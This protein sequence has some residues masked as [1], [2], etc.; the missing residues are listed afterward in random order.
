MS[1]I[2]IHPGA[3]IGRQDFI[4][5]VGP[6]LILPS[7]WLPVIWGDEEPVFETETEMRTVLGTIVGRYNEI[8]ASSTATLNSSIRSSG[9][10][11]R[12]R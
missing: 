7:E 1:S 4:D 6:E 9:K 8:V 12:A 2:A 10:G 3:L 11:R 5:V